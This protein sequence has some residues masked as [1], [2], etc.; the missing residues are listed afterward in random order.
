M[1]FS[2]TF[3]NNLGYDNSSAVNDFSNGSSWG[4]NITR[5]YADP[6]T[7]DNEWCHHPLNA[8]D[9]SQPYTGTGVVGGTGRFTDS[10]GPPTAPAT[11]YPA[12]RTSGG[13][14]MSCYLP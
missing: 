3:D 7:N 14:G 2:R 13:G 1:C 11:L 10:D 9:P 5:Q 8:G 4:N 6:S 12:D